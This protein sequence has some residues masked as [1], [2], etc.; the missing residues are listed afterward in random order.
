MYKRQIKGGFG[1]VNIISTNSGGT[2]AIKHIPNKYRNQA[3]IELRILRGARNPYIVDCLGY[4]ATDSGINIKMPAGDSSLHD[5]ITHNGPILG[6][7]LI[8]WSYQLLTALALLHANG[9]IHKD[10]K[11]SNILIFGNNL[12]VCDFGLCEINH[13]DKKGYYGTTIYSSPE[14]LIN[15]TVTMSCDIW[16]LGLTLYECKYGSRLFSYCSS[17]E[18][19]KEELLYFHHRFSMIS[20]QIWPYRIPKSNSEIRYPFG[21]DLVNDSKQDE[22]GNLILR[23][24]DIYSERILCSNFIQSDIYIGKT[25]DMNDIVIHLDENFSKVLSKVSFL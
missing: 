5:E 16:A 9:I 2:I 14:C 22:M 20:N 18:S 12:K 8:D 3:L 4:S 10:I 15:R 17:K 23:M 21:Y 6:S 24:L 1:V 11:P 7:K 13:T 19:T 25:L